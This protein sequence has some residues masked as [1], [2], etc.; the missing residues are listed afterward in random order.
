MD[1]NIEAVLSYA[2]IVDE[3]SG[4]V[5]LKKSGRSYTGLCPFHSEKTPSFHVSEPKGFYYCFGCGKGGNVINFLRDIKG[6][7]FGE[8]MDYLKKKYNVPIENI[9]FYKSDKNEG[10]ESG[11]KKI[12]NLALNFYYENLFVYLSGS[13]HII[14]YLKERGIDENTAGDFKLG[15][16]GLGNGLTTLLLNNK[17]DLNIAADIGLLFKKSGQNAGY[18]DRFTNKLIIPIM[19]R[20]GDPIAFAAR[21]VSQ[22]AGGPSSYNVPKYINTNNSKIFA[23]SNTLYG[24]DKAI[25]F[26]KKDNA[27][28]VVEGY[29]DMIML[30]SKGIKNV[31]ATMGTALSKNHI[32]NLSRLCDEIILLYDGD[33]AGINAINRGMELFLDFMDGTDKNIYAVCLNDGSDPDSFVR[34]Y[35]RDGL[36]KLVTNDKK[37]PVDFV[38][39]YYMEKIENSGIIPNED[40]IKRLKRK[41][42]VVKEVAPFLRKIDNN[43]ILSHYI[44]LLAN[45]LGLKENAIRDYI[46]SK[47]SFEQGVHSES[48][49]TS[50]P[51]TAFQ[52]KELSIEDLIVGRVFCEPLLT[53]YINDDIMKEFSDKDAIY[54]IK[55]VKKG[56]AGGI[57]KEK[58]TKLEEVVSKMENSLKWGK[59]YY[60][61]LLLSDENDDKNGREDFKKL[62]IKLKVDN[63]NKTCG[64]LSNEIKSGSLDEVGRLSRLKEISRLKYISRDFQRKICGF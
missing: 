6:E 30:Y 12:L 45:R 9:K 22:H 50:N 3:I 46:Y 18:C 4:F 14:K 53:E 63:I 35:G 34:K 33:K 28:F 15:Y 21:A 59:I 20:A 26:I 49:F 47:E 60:S 41:I 17:A 62:I 1:R 64:G 54:I 37:T 19:D 51:P 8:V 56:L 58:T 48:R 27:I 13:R 57:V 36:I 11:I 43:I 29:F 10:S 40:G 32:R 2:N 38:L 55:E 61:S 5:K 24:L 39:D 31:V 52:K 42:S 25:P 16:A 44:N 23:K 7:S